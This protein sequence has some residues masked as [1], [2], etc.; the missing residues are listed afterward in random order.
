VAKISNLRKMAAVCAAGVV[1]MLPGTAHAGLIS[2]LLGIVVPDCGPVTQPFAQFGDNNSYFP[3][4]NLGLE[5]GSNGW[6][7]SGG[8]RVVGGNEPWNVS[9]PGS[10]ALAL[11]PGASA[12][13]PATCINLL[14]P[15]IRTFASAPGATGSMRVD[16]QFRGLTGNLLGILNYGTFR[17]GDYPGWKPTANVASLLGLPVLTTSITIK[18]TSLASS[19]TWQVDDVYVDP[20]RMG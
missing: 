16:V 13:T 14:A 9:G 11:P 17:P 7:L 20:M 6:T 18:F 3:V 12:T 10:S 4:P 8:A 19:G 2:G 15:H 1:V 5:N